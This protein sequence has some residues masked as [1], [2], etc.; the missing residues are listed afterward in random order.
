ME[1][2]VTIAGISI[3]HSTTIDHQIQLNNAALGRA[4]EIA[5]EIQ[6]AQAQLAETR[7]RI[8]ELLDTF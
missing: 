2:Q 1:K 8:I 3:S 6:D 4:Q 5:L 7:R